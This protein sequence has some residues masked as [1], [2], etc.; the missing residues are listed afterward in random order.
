LHFDDE[1]AN[2]IAVLE[3]NDG[4]LHREWNGHEERD[5]QAD[6]KN[7]FEK[8]RAHQSVLARRMAESTALRPIAKKLA[9]AINMRQCV[10][11]AFYRTGAGLSR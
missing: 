10:A 1:T 5:E 2:P 4:G 9:A 7:G 8:V 11:C 6:R 3:H